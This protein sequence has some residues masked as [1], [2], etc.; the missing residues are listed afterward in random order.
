MSVHTD[1]GDV[2]LEPC[3]LVGLGIL[4]RQAREGC[5]GFSLL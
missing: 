1:D 2:A 4:D 3:P 5:V